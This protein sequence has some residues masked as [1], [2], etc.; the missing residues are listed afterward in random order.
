[1]HRV[2]STFTNDRDGYYEAHEEMH[3]QAERLKEMGLTERYG[4]YVD[5]SIRK[6]DARRRW[7]SWSVWL[8][9]RDTT[10]KVPDLT[11]NESYVS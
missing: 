4:V 5:K 11:D 2:I 8:V 9:D 3:R 1:M 7:A 10:L 6:G